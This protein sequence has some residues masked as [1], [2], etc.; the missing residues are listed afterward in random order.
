M[1]AGL[2]GLPSVAALGST[3]L[4]AAMILLGVALWLVSWAGLI[5]RRGDFGRPGSSFNR[6]QAERAA[7][8]WAF[9][10]FCAPLLLVLFGVLGYRSRSAPAPAK[11]VPAST[12]ASETPGASRPGGGARHAGHRR[13][14]ADGSNSP[15]SPGQRR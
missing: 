1:P 13:S 9:V 8:M 3:P 4:D 5:R 7:G 10:A 12:G 6:R 2:G 14:V 15:D 11:V